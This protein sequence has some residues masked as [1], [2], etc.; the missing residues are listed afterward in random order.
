MER[1]LHQGYSNCTWQNRKNSYSWI[2]CSWILERACERLHGCVDAVANNWMLI[3]L[4]FDWHY[5]RNWGVVVKTKA[6]RQWLE[7][8]N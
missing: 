6:A 3:A 2:M 5:G 1:W 8:G 4:T 7:Q